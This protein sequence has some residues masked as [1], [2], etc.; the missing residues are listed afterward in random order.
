LIVQAARLDL[1]YPFAEAAAL[2]GASTAVFRL[3]HGRWPG[4]PNVPHQTGILVASLPVFIGIALTAGRV[5]PISF[6][7]YTGF[8]VPLVLVAATGLWNVPLAQPEGRLARL[9]NHRYTPIVVL[10]ACLITFMHATPPARFFRILPNSLRYAIGAYSIDTAYTRQPDTGLF[11]VN[12]IYPG[13][14]GAYGIVGPGTPI[15]SMHYLSYCMLPDC[16]IESMYSFILPGWYDV[17]FGTAEQARNTLQKAGLDYFLFSRELPLEDTLPLSRLFSPD[18]ISQ[19]LGLRWTDGTTSLL[20]WLG[21]GVTPLTPAWLADYRN[22]IA[23]SQT[24]R[25][26]PY[27]AMKQ[28]FARL[29]ATPHPWRP[30]PLPW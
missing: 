4:L 3:R 9:I 2:I 26:Y 17:M 10:A 22:S 12:A 15:W 24:V 19:Y 11:P 20:T 7:R 6:Y 5:Q 27:A 8:A 13:A 23:E 28:I 29:N 16:R 14:R 18:S 25:S 21:P 1:I 30:F